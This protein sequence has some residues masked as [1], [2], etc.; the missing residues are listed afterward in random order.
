MCNDLSLSSNLLMTSYIQNILAR[1]RRFQKL[2]F[3]LEELK[4]PISRRVQ[5]YKNT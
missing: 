1:H 3:S 4:N 5:T 2:S